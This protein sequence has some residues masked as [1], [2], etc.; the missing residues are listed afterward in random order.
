MLVGVITASVRPEELIRGASEGLQATLS[1]CREQSEWSSHVRRTI[2][3]QKGEGSWLMK[4]YAYWQC[5]G[6][7]FSEVT[8]RRGVSM[9]GVRLKMKGDP[10][11][12]GQ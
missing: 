11:H 10:S 8:G 4:G 3:V 5:Q 1:T 9:A 2:Q 6:D 7:G 12:Q